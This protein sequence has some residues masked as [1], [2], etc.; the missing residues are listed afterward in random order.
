ME[1]K[2]VYLDMMIEACLFPGQGLPAADIIGFYSKLGGIDPQVTSRKIAQAQEALNRVHG[3][4]EFNVLDSLADPSSPSFKK[5][6]FVQPV[7]Y[8]LSM[9]AYDLA[10]EHRL[11]NPAVVAGQS[12]GEYSAITAAGVVNEEEGVD[13]VAHRGHYM[14][15]VYDGDHSTLMVFMD[16]PLETVQ[17][18]CS[19]SAKPKVCPEGPA[20]I[21]IYSA[22][23]IFVV[24][25]AE[26]SVPVIEKIA[27][28]VEV[29]KKRLRLL[30]TAGAF[31][32]TYERG[33][34]GKLKER[35]SAYSF[36]RVQI[37]VVANL[38]GA[39]IEEDSTYS[40]AN[41]VQSM[42]EPIQWSHTIFTLRLVADRFIEVGPGNS[43]QILNGRNGVPREQTTNVLNCFIPQLVG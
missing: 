8:A 13:L 36:Q 12:L 39:I 18:I 38:S 42:T 20:E 41:L 21:A 43:L 1:E 28:Q 30:E 33:A 19:E 26:K 6:A 24:G 35:L 25:C 9:T 23:N 17:A 31:H 5:T 32:T 2:L 29:P 40:T 16:I 7:T 4:S 11:L 10:K 14:Q 3:S 15:D 22:P 37:P 27:E 34:A